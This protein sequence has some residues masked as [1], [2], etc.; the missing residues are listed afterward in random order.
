MNTDQI[1]TDMKDG[2][3]A[4]F[5]QN[6]IVQGKESIKLGNGP[7]GCVI[8]KDGQI[9]A[10]GHNEESERCDPTAHA[11]M[12]TIQKLCKELQLKKLSG[13]TLYSTLQPCAMCTVACIWAGITEIVYGARRGDVSLKYFTERHI[14]IADLVHDAVHP[15][16]TLIPGVLED[17][18]SRLYT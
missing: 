11:E 14:D 8:V 12:V 1:E 7:T 18:G 5:M 4:F 6:A 16:I 2:S 13:C 9:I 17:E 10:V 3:H 15:D